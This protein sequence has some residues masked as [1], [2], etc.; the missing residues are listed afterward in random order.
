MRPA[1]S[2]A[3]AAPLDAVWHELTD[4]TAWPSWAPTVRSAELDGG[5]TR[6][7]A[8]ATGWV[9]TAVGVRLPFTVDGWREDAETRWWSWRV[10]GVHATE[11][12]VEAT[13][14]GTCR[15]RMSVP[16]WAPAYLAVVAPALMSIR[17]RAEDGDRRPP[18]R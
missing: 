3:V 9:T 7:R 18:A 13:G 4:L 8:N 12:A 10:A 1:L 6:L 5:G 2:I 15:L 11:H 14:A 16:W 17:R